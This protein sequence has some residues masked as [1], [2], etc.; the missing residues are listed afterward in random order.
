M[1]RTLRALFTTAAIMAGAAA[2]EANAE[3]IGPF[4]SP[5]DPIVTEEFEPIVWMPTRTEG[6]LQAKIDGLEKQI[7][8]EQR[9]LRTI[10]E[11]F[12][13]Q[14]LSD[15]RVSTLTQ[16]G[17]NWQRQAIPFDDTFY[18]AVANPLNNEM[19]AFIEVGDLAH[20]KPDQA[21]FQRDLATGEGRIL[22]NVIKMPQRMISANTHEP[23]FRAYA[24]PDSIC[25]DG[26]V[27]ETSEDNPQLRTITQDD[28][29]YTI[30][31]RTVAGRQYTFGEIG[32]GRA[33][34]AIPDNTEI[35]P[36]YIVRLEGTTFN[37]ANKP[38]Y[39]GL[40]FFENTTTGF[41]ALVDMKVSAIGEE[42]ANRREAVQSRITGLLEKVEQAKSEA[43][44]YRT[45]VQQ[46]SPAEAVGF[47]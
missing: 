31:V 42:L 37:T 17:T 14:P 2:Y 41:Y 36:I 24:N 32:K 29:V 13:I 9:T 1:S 20:P 30:P 26:T 40:P 4:P 22:S 7:K 5:I 38:E 6:E 10:P 47:E 12:E 34:L 27:L 18:I 35:E 45:R 44:S 46:Q 16:E 11:T 3:D 43:D 21:Y 39:E 25:L 19:P 33:S 28:V 23:V 15:L 8:T